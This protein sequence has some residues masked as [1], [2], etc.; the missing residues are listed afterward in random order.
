MVDLLNGW[1]AAW[2]PYFLLAVIQNIVFLSLVFLAL[3][4]LRQAPAR[5]LSLIATLGVIKLAT[6]PFVSFGWMDWLGSRPVEQVAQPVSFLLFPFAD[7]GGTDRGFATGITGGFSVVALLMMVWLSIA[8]TRLGSGLLQTLQLAFD[9]QGAKRLDDAE[10][11]IELRQYGL[12]VWRCDR[13]ALP[14]T[15]GLR[16]R[17]IF[18]PA[19]WDSWPTASLVVI[20]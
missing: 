12:S 20:I 10:L 5:L 2:G 8:L 13:I 17:R 3:H 14:L 7:L 6:P 1:A 19:S 15:L 16:P 11:P 18:V 4:L 9:I